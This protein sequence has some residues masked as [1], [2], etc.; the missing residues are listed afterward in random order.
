MARHDHGKTGRCA[1]RA[2]AGAPQA[3]LPPRRR[4]HHQS[5]KDVGAGLGGTALSPDGKVIEGLVHKKYPHVFSVQFHPEVPN[6]YEEM[7]DV[8]LKF[9]PD[10]ALETIHN[11][12]DRKSLKFHRQ[13]WAHISSVIEAQAK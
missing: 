6:L 11:M 8:K 5:V 7:N 2:G 9:S 13:D 4:S 10:D 3:L 1:R 12:L